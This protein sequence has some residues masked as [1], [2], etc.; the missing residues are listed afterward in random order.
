M[1]NCFFRATGFRPRRTT[2]RANISGVNSGVSEN[3]MLSSGSASTRFQSVR[4]FLEVACLFIFR[5]LSNRD[6]ANRFAGLGVRDYHHTP[7]E[8]SQRGKPELAVIKSVIR[9]GD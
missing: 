3:S 5:C 1:V 6:D 2:A 7:G 9:D 8:Q 4:D